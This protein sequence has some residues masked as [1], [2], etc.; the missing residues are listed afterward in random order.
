MKK[1]SGERIQFWIKCT[2]TEK[3]FNFFPSVAPRPQK[4]FKKY[5]ENISNYFIS[6][7]GISQIL[8]TKKPNIFKYFPNL[9]KFELFLAC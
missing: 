4:I 5:L 8:E 6:N 9:A 3:V 1:I 2:P 7:C